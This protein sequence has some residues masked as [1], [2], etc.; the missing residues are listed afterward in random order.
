MPSTA[1]TTT[2]IL[3]LS[4]VFDNIGASRAAATSTGAFNVWRN[5][6]SAEHLPEPGTTVTVDEVPFLVPPFGTGGPDNVRCAGQ[7]LEVE[8]DR[9]DWLY[10]LAAAER[11]VED[12]VALH[13]ADGT[14]DFE[15]LRLSDFWAAPAVF[16]ESEAFRT[17]AMHYPQHVQFG[18][19]AGLF[20][21]RVPVTRR[22]PLAGV[23]LPRNTAVHV[24][25]ATLL[26]AA[27]AAGGPRTTDLTGAG[28]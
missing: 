2:R 22:A 8:P 10:L 6:F 28:R 27:A 1:S 26:R 19:P 21:Q 23:R 9:Y 7:L 12:E 14:V 13:F 18:V 25:A 15:A 5:S 24:F 20:C 16:G 3:D 17:P 4:A 11:R